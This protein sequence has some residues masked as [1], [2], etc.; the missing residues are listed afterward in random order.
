MRA[1]R[2]AASESSD[3]TVTTQAPMSRSS[4]SRPGLLGADPHVLRHV[5]VGLARVRQRV[6]DALG[7]LARGRKD[8]GPFMPPILIGIGSWTGLANV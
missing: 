5:V 2:L 4:K 3:T 1:A 8:C 7:D 6:V